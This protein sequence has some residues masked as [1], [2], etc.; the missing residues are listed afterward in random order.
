MS[1]GK[2]GEENNQQEG[3]QQ[4]GGQ[5]KAQ[6]HQRTPAEWVTLGVSA[7]IILALVGLITYLA[8]RPG[9]NEPVLQVQTFPGQMRKNGGFYYLPVMVTNNGN[10][11]VGN[12]WVGFQLSTGQG[13]AETS[14]ITMNFLA[15][16]DA[17][18]GQVAFQHDPTQGALKISFSFIYP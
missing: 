4:Q 6:Q 3:G 15:T 2:Q 11:T 12:V 13:Q 18:R 17:Q 14:Q 16:H 8:F 9:S 5:P 1:A 7:L 10:R